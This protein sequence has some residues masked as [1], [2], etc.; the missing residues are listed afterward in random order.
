M[1]ILSTIQ[2]AI[3]TSI[4]FGTI[5]NAAN[6]HL[7]PPN[8]SPTFEDEGL[9]LQ[10]SGKLAGLGNGDIVITMTAQA[11]VFSTCTNKG[12]TQAPG[13]NPAPLTVSGTDTIPQAEIKNGNVSFTVAT[14]APDP[15]IAGAPDCPN[16]NWT[17]AIEDLA[18]TSARITVEQP[19]GY[20]ALQIHCEFI[21]PTSD[22]TVPNNTVYCNW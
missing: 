15:I 1:R 20:D 9:S 17:E 11:D 8:K 4:L 2:Y 10:I 3:A 21:P 14:Q 12:G 7:K 13:Q 5:A 6:V 18:F 19:M 22:G 16:K